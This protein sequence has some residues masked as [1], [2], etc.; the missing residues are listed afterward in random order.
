MKQSY[1]FPNVSSST[2]EAQTEC[3]DLGAATEMHQIKSIFNPHKSRKKKMF[4]IIRLVFLD[5]V[6]YR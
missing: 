5:H 6:F 4:K 2:N 1:S 3:I